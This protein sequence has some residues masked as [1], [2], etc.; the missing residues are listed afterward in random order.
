M[1]MHDVTSLTDF[2][3]SKASNFILFWIFSG[4]LV[5]EI[6]FN[7]FSVQFRENSHCR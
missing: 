1:S 3:R 4:I 2:K 6:A 7:F 5:Q